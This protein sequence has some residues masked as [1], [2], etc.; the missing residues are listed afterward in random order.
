MK[1]EISKNLYVQQQ[2]KNGIYTSGNV[3]KGEN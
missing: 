1:L 3:G 2:S